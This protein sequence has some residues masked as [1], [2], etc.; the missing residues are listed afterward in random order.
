MTSVAKREETLFSIDC[1]RCRRGSPWNWRLVSQEGITVMHA[2]MPVTVRCHCTHRYP[3][4]WSGWNRIRGLSI[5]GSP[6]P[7]CPAQWHESSWPPSSW[8][9]HRHSSEIYW[10]WS[11]SPGTHLR[12]R[13]S[14]RPPEWSWWATCS[15]MRLFW[16]KWVYPSSHRRSNTPLAIHCDS[17]PASDPPS[18]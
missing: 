13:R 14:C 15:T 5:S 18:N 12:C 9:C 11:K 2:L 6:R 8:I 10:P 3:E 4:Q 16:S 7:S 1:F 17:P